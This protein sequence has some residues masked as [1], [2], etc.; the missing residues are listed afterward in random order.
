MLSAPPDPPVGTGLDSVAEIAGRRRL[1]WRVFAGLFTAPTQ[2]WVT[3]LRERTVQAELSRAVGWRTGE[4]DRFGVPLNGLE[5]FARVS[6]RR[7]LQAEVTRLEAEFERLEARCANLETAAAACELMTVL[8]RDEAAAW[9]AASV[10]RGRQ[11]RSHQTQE[12]VD[13]GAAEVVEAA[14]RA[15]SV[16]EPKQPYKALAEFCREW[17]RVE[18]GT[19]IIESIR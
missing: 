8:C 13:G 10:A 19:G 16:A 5:T 3:E 18:L 4:L 17:L 6:Q 7:T 14:L 9:S 15:M 1:G 11:L 12:L 2:E